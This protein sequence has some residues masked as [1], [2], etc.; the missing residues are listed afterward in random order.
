MDDIYISVMIEVKRFFCK[1]NLLM[2]LLMMVLFL[3]G[4]QKGI[5]SYEYNFVSNNEFQKLEAAKIKKLTSYELYSQMGV[6]ITF[7]PT[8]PVIFLAS[9]MIPEE[10]AAKVNS[11][12]AIDIYNNFKGRLHNRI[13]SRF[14]IQFSE[15]VLLLGGL[16]ALFFGY[17]ALRHKEYLK[18]ISSTVDNRIIYFSIITARF[19]LL[20][21][22]F[23][24]I[25]SSSLFLV[26]IEGITFPGI[27]FVNIF[28]YLISTFLLILFFF[29]I[30][31]VIGGSWSNRTGL[32]VVLAVWL[33][34]IWI[35]PGIINSIVEEKNEKMLSPYMLENN[36]L[37]IVDRFE[38]EVIKN[39]GKR[40]DN[41]P[42]GR[43]KVVEGYWNNE[44]KNIEALE[45][46]YK[47]QLT[48]VFNKNSTLSLLLPTTFYT[49]TAGEV[50]SRGY[51][52][53]LNFYSY[54]Q[55]MQSKFLRFWLDRVYYDEPVK[56]QSFIKGDENI[57]QGQSR[58][59]KNFLFG[60]S[61][62]LFY[63]V[64]LL[65]VSF[66]LFKR[67]MFPEVEDKN[68]YDQLE[69]EMN[70]GEVF[71][72]NHYTP[73][74]ADQFYNALTG[75]KDS[76]SMPWKLSLDG[77][78]FVKSSGSRFTY[79][80]NIDQIPGEIRVCSL[81]KYFR[82]AS[83]SDEDYIEIVGP[84]STQQSKR[85]DKLDQKDQAGVLVALAE[86]RREQ[87][88]II[89]FSNFFRGVPPDDR[90]D[91]TDRVDMLADSGIFILDLVQDNLAWMP[92][93]KLTSIVLKDKKFKT[94]P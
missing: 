33:I 90:G 53:Y 44:F 21:F 58:L 75:T 4:V 87:T 64:V 91:V 25:L 7:A 71:S 17:D 51:Q 59:P 28:G 43:R 16:M 57:F 94:H 68:A 66:I 61:L 40:K 11:I 69:L 6:N 85:F 62:N 81:F 27:N 88:D 42:E 55:Q 12:I 10:F 32:F 41:T 24:F 45:E 54:L 49:L 76:M 20:I 56:M 80:P 2:L 48:I 78:D 14:Q 18:F 31:T 37:Q 63:C 67:R 52:N 22:C 60:L 77:K 74:L 19:L 29:L 79:I 5:N 89:M 15:L 30:G 38:S 72:I 82:P 34:I 26:M 1:K 23:L 47:Q 36:K 73:L 50:S 83:L 8:F 84:Y 35:M 39:H 65:V 13:N 46:Q 92:T 70:S 93:E 3:Y 86:M 9:T